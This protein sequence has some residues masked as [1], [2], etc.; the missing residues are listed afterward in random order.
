MQVKSGNEKAKQKLLKSQCGFAGPLPK[1][2]CGRKTENA[3]NKII[4][5]KTFSKGEQIKGSLPLITETRNKIVTTPTVTEITTKMISIMKMMTNMVTVTDFASSFTTNT[6]TNASRKKPT[7][8]PPTIT[9][10]TTEKNFEDLETTPFTK[11]APPKLQCVF[12]KLIFFFLLLIGLHYLLAL[13]GQ[14]FSVEIF[15]IMFP[16]Y[17]L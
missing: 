10:S 2:C 13:E 15:C 16:F 1:V 3:A 8:K 9:E 12:L 6:S 11:P 5:K 7:T 17:N 4:A 14:K